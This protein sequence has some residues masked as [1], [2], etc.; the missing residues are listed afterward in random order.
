MNFANCLSIEFDS[1]SHLKIVQYPPFHSVK[2][3][4]S[5]QVNTEIEK[6]LLKSKI[7]KVPRDIRRA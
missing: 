1:L 7:E 3:I 4:E 6:K 2:K 5:K